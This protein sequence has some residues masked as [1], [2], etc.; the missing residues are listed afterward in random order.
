[1]RRPV[2]LL[3]LT[4]SAVLGL[5][6]GVATATIVHRPQGP[7]PLGLGIPLVDQQCSGK[8]VLVTAWGTSANALAP[9]VAENPDHTRYLDV[10]GSCRAPWKQHGTRTEGYIAYLGPYPSVAQACQVRMT[11][12]HRGDLVTRLHEG[13][14]GSVQCLCYVDFAQMPELRPGMVADAE[15]SIYIRALQDLLAE[16]GLNKA[17]DLTGIYDAQTVAAVRAYQAGRSTPS[18]PGFVNSATWHSLVGQCHIYN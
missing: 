10:S 11:A 6:G 16:L 13:T 15:E 12:S 18:R 14:A 7:D 4:V 2:R 8:S 9:A 5:V 17:D 1:M 3:A